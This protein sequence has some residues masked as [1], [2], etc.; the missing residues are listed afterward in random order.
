MDIYDATGGP[1]WTTR[2]GWGE[3]DTICSWTGVTCENGHVTGLD[4]Y[5]N[6]LSGAFAITQG[7]LN[8]LTNLSLMYN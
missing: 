5:N 6:N 2:V 7:N 8:S 4:L 1:S 3:S